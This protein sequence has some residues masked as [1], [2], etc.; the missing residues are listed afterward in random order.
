[1]YEQPSLM[2]LVHPS[3]GRRM[4]W[5]VFEQNLLLTEGWHEVSPEEYARA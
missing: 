3:Q 2:Y 5:T 4:S 1:M